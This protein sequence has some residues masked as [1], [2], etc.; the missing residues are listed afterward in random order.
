MCQ[1][2]LAVGCEMTGGS[3]STDCPK[4]KDVRNDGSV[5][6]EDT[7]IGD[8]IGREATDMQGGLPM[9]NYQSRQSFRAGNC[10]T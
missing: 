8:P 10:R 9:D 7:C 4:H 1:C 3:N 5:T 2:S 6:D